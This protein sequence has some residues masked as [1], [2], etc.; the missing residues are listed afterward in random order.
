MTTSTYPWPGFITDV[1]YPV[2]LGCV[3]DGSYI[4]VVWR[5]LASLPHVGWAWRDVLLECTWDEFP[6]RHSYTLLFLTKENRFVRDDSFLS[7]VHTD[8]VLAEN[9]KEMC[10]REFTRAAL[11]AQPSVPAPVP[12]PVLEQLIKRPGSSWDRRFRCLAIAARTG[13]QCEL[14]TASGRDT[15]W[16]HSGE[17]RAPTIVTQE[18]AAGQRIREAVARI[19]GAGFSTDPATAAALIRE[20]LAELESALAERN[21]FH[22]RGRV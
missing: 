19:D 12:E 18:R 3:L 11:S 1:P 4:Q 6:G 8:P 14:P 16:Q 10:I 9:A 20:G 5:V 7:L 15:C 17:R 2:G 22:R 13:R 21:A